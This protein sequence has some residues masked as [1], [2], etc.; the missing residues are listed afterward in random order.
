[1]PIGKVWI[2]GYTVYCLFVFFFVRLRITPAKIKLAASNFAPWFVSVLGRKSSILG[3]FTPSEVQNWT[4]RPA[5]GKY[6][7]GCISLSTVNVTLEMRR[8]WNIARRVDVG[9]HASVPTDVLV[10]LLILFKLMSK[11]HSLKRLVR[12]RPT[13]CLR[14]RQIT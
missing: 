1:M 5:T 14:M 11:L 3:N 12:T 2:Y 7:L 9:R 13:R 6:G 8:S 10:L 4:N